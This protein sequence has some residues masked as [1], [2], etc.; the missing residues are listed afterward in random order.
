M[1]F[2]MKT[3][4][5]RDCRKCSD[6]VDHIWVR[7]RSFLFSDMR[8]W[9]KWS[10]ETRFKEDSFISATDLACRQRMLIPP[11]TC[12]CP[13]WDVCSCVETSPIEP[14]HV[15]QTLFQHHPVLIIIIHLSKTLNQLMSLTHDSLTLTIYNHVC[16]KQILQCSL[17]VIC[18]LRRR[19]IQRKWNLAHS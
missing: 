2:S 19:K 13:I 8:V 4:E 18:T 12:S 17:T 7:R 9:R 5:T 15:N 1:P 14:C 6:W 10:V 16:F 3:K 11:N